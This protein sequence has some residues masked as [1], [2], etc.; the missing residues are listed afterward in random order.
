MQHPGIAT[1]FFADSF[2]LAS[3]AKRLFGTGIG[4]LIPEKENSVGTA[5]DNIT[6]FLVVPQSSA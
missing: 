4:T 6:N 3:E 5:F 2:C 1:R